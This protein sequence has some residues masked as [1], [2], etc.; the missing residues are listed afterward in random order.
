[1]KILKYLLLLVLI[2]IIGGA[3]YL[4]TLDGKFDIQRTKVIDAPTALVYGKVNDFT[5][6]ESWSPWLYKD[7]NTKLT[8]SDITS[9][10]GASYS[11]ESDNDEV[12]S[13]SM[14]TVEAVANES[15]RQKIT[16]TDPWEQQSNIYWNFKPAE[17]GG[18]EVTWGMQ[19]E[20]PF[21][22]RYMAAKMDEYVGPDYDKGLAKLDSVIQSDMKKYSIVI[23]GETTHSG[24]YYLY[25]TTS[26]KIDEMP[27]KMA[28]MMPKVGEYAINNKITMAG[29]AFSLYH[30][31]DEENNAVI[32]SCAV[33]VSERV[34][35]AKDSGILTGMLRPFKALKTTL[36]GDYDNLAEAWTKAQN[37]MAENNLEGI[38]GQ[39]ALEVY[40]NDP[41]NHPNPANWV[42]EI[43]I[44]VK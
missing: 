24:G 36:T 40:T 23:N 13:G 22:A 9:G 42:T 20:M 31:F 4:A 19:G 12:G 33:P 34:I 3:I 43:Y 16:F 32:F 44:P 1:M 10:E 14:E 21:M 6:W 2:V 28:E 17:G 41:M 8:Y 11:W 7:P 25:N 38:Q 15:L 30:K 27:E 18:T 29:P 26:C 37:Y 35:T 39:P 5:T